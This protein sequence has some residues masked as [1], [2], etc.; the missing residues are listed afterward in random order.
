MAVD[1]DVIAAAR[2]RLAQLGVTVADLQRADRPKVPTVAEYLP[3]V[4]AAANVGSRRAYGTYWQRMA[5]V[6]AV[7]AAPWP[8]DSATSTSTSTAAWSG[9]GRRPG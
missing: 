5:A 2:A 8:Y 3:R 1:P 9:Y 7:A 4:V 6:R